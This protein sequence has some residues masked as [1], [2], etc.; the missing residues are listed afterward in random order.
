M[1][2]YL[3]AGLAGL[4][5]MVVGR[6]ASAQEAQTAPEPPG[7]R[8]VPSVEDAPAPPPSVARTVRIH[9]RSKENKQRVRVETS[10]IGGERQL[11]CSSE[12]PTFPPRQR[13]ARRRPFASPSWGDCVADVPPGSQLRI[14]LGES[15]ESHLFEVP[16]APG[17]EMNLTV[18][19]AD[20]T[21]EK[22]GGIA[23]IVIGSVGVALGSLVLAF[24]APPGLLHDDD[25]ATQS[26]FVLI[27]G[28][29]FAAGGI[30]VL[31]TGSREP[32]VESA[33]TDRAAARYGRKDTVNGDVASARSRE[34]ST[35]A[36]AAVT[37]LSYG[38]TF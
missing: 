32:H 38:F 27:L 1:T 34:P 10:V 33:A 23:L 25:L 20:R 22:A 4:S 35:T 3:I 13:G 28:A 29:A 37:P 14:S 31:A 11:L 16:D 6:G 30:A 7:E 21:A 19:N 12:A 9:A 36:P 17:S 26:A 8:D 15:E 24:S 2:R 18:L 5:L